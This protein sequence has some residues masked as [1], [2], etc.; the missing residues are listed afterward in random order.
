MT[1]PADL[2]L[3]NAEVHT[4]APAGGP[5][6]DG[7]GDETHEA[8]AVRDGRV[9]AVGRAY[10]VEFLAGAGTEVRDCGGRVVLPGFVDAHTHLEHTGAYVVHADLSDAASVDDA[11]DALAAHAESTDDEWVQGRGWDESDWPA[12][13]YLRRADLDRVSEDRPVL[14]TRVDGHLAALNSVALERVRDA[15]PDDDVHTEDSEASEDASGSRTQS[16]DGDPTGV[17]VE[18]AV[19]AVREEIGGDVDSARRLF[20]AGRD[21]AHELGVTAVH[22]MV[23]DSHAPRVARD[24]AAAGDLDLRYRVN[25]WSD[26]L[27]AVLE[28][29]LRTGSGG[30]FVTVGGVKSFTDGSF[31]GRTAKVTE[32][33]ADGEG[34][35][36][37]VVDPDEYRDLVARVDDAGLQMV[38]HAIGDAAVHE[39]VE[40]YDDTGDQGGARHR[41]EHVEFH[42]DAHLETMA[43]AGTVASVQPNFH[44]WAQPGG[45]YDARLGEDRRRRTNRFRGLHDAGVPLAFGSDSMPMGPLLGVHHAV[46]APAER[47]RLSVTE[48]L[49]AY[50]YG[51]AYAAFEED[52]MG[53]VRAG[54]VADLVVLDDS[55][56]ERE[57]EISDVDVA[58]TVVGGEVVYEA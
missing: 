14:A 5:Y 56:W 19:E 16:G 55:P 21:R 30:E 6:P 20:E 29:G 44:Q 25:Y 58:A 11:V 10:D 31:G 3:T 35:G 49:R 45:L 41:I 26:H 42:D 48:A 17:V 46:N 32:P 37:W 53:S 38:T 23:R 33:Y 8:V 9:V 15:L 39:V 27:D 52:R 34:T 18:D 47:Q 40:T 54:N 57:D 2:V 22:D 36:Q 1:A 13:R 51:G 24:L 4:L 28:T 50:T 7:P 12:D 43:E